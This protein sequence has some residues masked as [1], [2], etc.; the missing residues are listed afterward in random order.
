MS[1]AVKY[2][3]IKIL[4]VLIFSILSLVFCFVDMDYNGASAQ[5]TDLPVVTVQSKTVH[6]GQTFSIDVELEN[7][8]GFTALCLELRK[9][10]YDTSV[11]TLTDVIRKDALSSL[12]YTQTGTDSVLGYDVDYFRMLWDGINQDF[13]T[14]TLVSFV[15]E[16]NIEAEVGEYDIVLTYDTFNTKH[17]YGVPQEIEI[18][19]GKITLIKGEYSVN[20]LNY[21]GS[22]LYTK[23]YNEDDIPSYQGDAPIKLE[24]ACYTYTFAGWKGVVSEE[25]NTICY[26]AQYTKTPKTYQILYYIADYQGGEIGQFDY[27]DAVELDYNEI[28]QIPDM[29]HRTHYVFHGWYVDEY[30]TTPLSLNFM[31]AD[32]LT[33][34]GYYKRDIRETNIPK[35]TLTQ[36]RIE[37]QIVYVD[38]HLTINTGFNGL[39]ISPE[40]DRTVLRLVGFSRGDKLLEM[41]FDTTHTQ[42]YNEEGFKFYFE[43]ATNNYET[44]LFLTLQFE[45][46]SEL[47]ERYYPVSFTY[48]PFRDATYVMSNK[49]IS[50]TLLEIIGANVSVG[51]R[52]HWIQEVADAPGINIEVTSVDGKPLDTELEVKLTTQEVLLGRKKINEVMGRN[53]DLSSAYSIKLTQNGVEIAPNTTLYIKITLNREELDSETIKFG[54]LSDA[55]VLTEHQYEVELNTLSFTTDHLSNWIIFIGSASHNTAYSGKITILI[56]LPSLLAVATMQYVLIIRAKNK[57]LLQRENDTKGDK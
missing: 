30:C 21:D 31:P 4:L 47:E 11:F 45:I 12:T 36:N 8:V 23:D 7:N 42:D 3:N 55:N 51:L 39:V 28:I 25:T 5:N 24:D 50:Y 44:G 14:G 6:R 41:Q 53:M 56:L 22:V 54:Y 16:S 57:K 38:C 46:I 17:E 32:D 34:Y 10:G 13:S 20:Y 26:M 52:F 18:V 48:E 9:T 33:L 27:Y 1:K 35:I 43:S 37:N 2:T 15:F 19:N 40:Y 49:E 29:P